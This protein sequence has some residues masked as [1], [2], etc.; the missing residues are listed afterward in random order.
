MRKSLQVFC[1][2][3]GNVQLLQP[4]AG[5][6]CVYPRSKVLATSGLK[7]L[8]KYQEET[9]GAYRCCLFIYLVL[10]LFVQSIPV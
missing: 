6:S 5:R 3:T 4:Q 8:A 2:F 9:L 1:L 7:G 10:S